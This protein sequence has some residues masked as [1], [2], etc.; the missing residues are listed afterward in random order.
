MLR[1]MWL[2]RRYDSISRGGM[3]F[4]SPDLV[5]ERNAKSGL[6]QKRI[7]MFHDVTSLNL[8]FR[9]GVL[10]DEAFAMISMGI[11]I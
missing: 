6:R 2:K 7:I 11:D 1:G 9:N 5:P 4:E 10:M 8:K 3:C